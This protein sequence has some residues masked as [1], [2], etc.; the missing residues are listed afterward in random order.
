MTTTRRRTSYHAKN[1][2][3]AGTMGG[4]LNMVRLEIDW[5][6]R[7]VDIFVQRD[8]NCPYPFLVGSPKTQEIE[9]AHEGL[10][11]EQFERLYE[12]LTSVRNGIRRYELDGAN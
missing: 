2:K 6:N 1:V 12:Q 10:G 8:R 7:V 4:L 11:F 3:V 9:E 5:R